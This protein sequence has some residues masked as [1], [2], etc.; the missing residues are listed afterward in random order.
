M[1]LVGSNTLRS[2]DGHRAVLTGKMSGT[3]DVTYRGFFAIGRVSS[4]SDATGNTCIAQDEWC[5]QNRED[6]QSH[7]DLMFGIGGT[8]PF[9]GGVLTIAGKAGTRM[10]LAWF[11]QAQTAISNKKQHRARG[12]HRR[13]RQRALPDL[14]GLSRRRRQ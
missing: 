10:G 6:H 4:D 7:D 14:R 13:H 11:G 5:L 8:R 1:T 12:H 9:G 3:G 2:L